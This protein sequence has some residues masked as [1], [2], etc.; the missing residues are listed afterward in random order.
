MKTV[1]QNK[2]LV[3]LTFWKL[4]QDKERDLVEKLLVESRPDGWTGL[5]WGIVDDGDDDDDDNDKTMMTMMTLLLMMMMMM[6]M[7]TTT[8]LACNIRRPM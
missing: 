7:V 3:A 1:S 2:D 6:A 4:D 5:A 8:S